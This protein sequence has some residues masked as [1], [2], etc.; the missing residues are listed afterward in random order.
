M[1]AAGEHGARPALPDRIHAQGEIAM[2]LNT[3][4]ALASQV[5]NRTGRVTKWPFVVAGALAAASAIDLATGFSL[6]I[7]DAVIAEV[8]AVVHQADER[9]SRKNAASL[10]DLATRF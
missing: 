7:P 6:T 8:E 5:S 2:T 9:E 4:F 1:E 3:A 10:E